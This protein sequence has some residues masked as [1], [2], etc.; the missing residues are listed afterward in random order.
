M[1]AQESACLTLTVGLQRA[2]PHTHTLCTHPLRPQLLSRLT[3]ASRSASWKYTL[4]STRS[5]LQRQSHSVTSR[6]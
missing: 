4:L 5:A 3:L 6:V 1:Q 2:Q